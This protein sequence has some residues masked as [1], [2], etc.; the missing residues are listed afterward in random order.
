MCVGVL[1]GDSHPYIFKA[2]KS[3]ACA[4]ARET[5]TRGDLERRRA[6]A[7]SPREARDSETRTDACERGENQNVCSLMISHPSPTA[8]AHLK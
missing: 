6:R 8:L 7:G 5:H 1:E 2:E 4:C 3:C